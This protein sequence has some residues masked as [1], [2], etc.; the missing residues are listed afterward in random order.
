MLKFR[1]ERA[2]SPVWMRPLLPLLAVLITFVITSVFIL[3]AKANPLTAY[4]YYLTSP[5]T[6]RV[7]MIEILVKATPLILTGASVTI[8]FASGYWNIGAEGQLYAGALAAAWI[9]TEVGGWHPLLA[10]LAMLLGGF[11]AGMIWASI[12]ALLK[13]KLAVDEVVTTLLL[14]SVIVFIISA[15]LNGP[16]RD[17]VSGWPQSPTIADSA[18]F[19][20]LI[21]RSR[22]H[23]GFVVAVMMVL[24]IWFILSKTPLGLR[25]RASGLGQ[26]AARFMGVNIQ[27][28]M[29]IA[30]LLSGGIAGLAGVGEVAGIHFHLIDALSNG[31]G[32]TG[33]IA[34][35]LGGL[36]P[37]GAGLAAIFL[38]LLDTGAQSVSRSLGVPIFLGNV[39]QSTLLLVTLGVFMLQ[40][41]RIRRV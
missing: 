15:L 16:W 20:K 41:Y 22:L 26:E 1:I 35:T 21:P 3:L 38:G 5:F 27:R 25:M 39:V 23:L 10:I 30:A 14:N 31:L 6:N 29:L 40:N 13:V 37:F 24:L 2:P 34:A 28:T 33:I 8:A 12:P 9:G 11:L 18:V 17:P 36:N 19:P 7:S 4:Y 32:Y